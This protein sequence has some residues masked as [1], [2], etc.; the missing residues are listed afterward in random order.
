VQLVGCASAIAAAGHAIRVLDKGLAEA[1]VKH[2]VESLVQQGNR[3]IPTRQATCSWS[4]PGLGEIM[5]LRA[6]RVVY[7]LKNHEGKT[8]YMMVL[9]K[10]YLLSFYA[11]DPKRVAW[12]VIAAY[13]SSC[14]KGNGVAR[15]R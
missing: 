7:E 5:V 15:I 8:T 11:K 14:E 4:R 13:K 9:G 6:G 2:L 1:S 12:V 3:T 10:P